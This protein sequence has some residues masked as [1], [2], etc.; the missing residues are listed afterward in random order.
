M[1][2][3]HRLKD[4]GGELVPDK[5]AELEEVSGT[6]NIWRTNYESSDNRKQLISY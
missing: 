5:D 1:V 4:V 3:H 2:T 6:F